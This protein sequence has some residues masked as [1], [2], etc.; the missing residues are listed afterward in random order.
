[1]AGAPLFPNLILPSLSYSP[2]STPVTH[3]FAILFDGCKA[4]HRTVQ[5]RLWVLQSPFI[6][7]LNMESWR[8]AQLTWDHFWSMADDPWLRAVP[9]LFGKARTCRA[10]R[11]KNHNETDPVLFPTLATSSS[12]SLLATILGNILL[13]HCG[14]P[15]CTLARD[16]L[17][18]A[19]A[20]LYTLQ[21][22][23]VRM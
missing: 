15:H 22:C 18:A 3:S 14:W 16:S 9:S 7:V 13:G 4:K 20:P 17:C 23:L 1:M 11:G 12:L 2:S 19:T 8:K 21:I 6:S 5:G 10:K